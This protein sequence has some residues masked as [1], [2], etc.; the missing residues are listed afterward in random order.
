MPYIDLSP[1]TAR[2]GSNRRPFSAVQRNRAAARSTTTTT[3]SSPMAPSSASRRT[4]R[5]SPPTAQPSCFARQ[6][7]AG[8]PIQLI[9]PCLLAGARLPRDRARP[10]GLYHHADFACLRDRRF[11]LWSDE[12]EH[13]HHADR[14]KSSIPAQPLSLVRQIFQYVSW[15]DGR[16][17]H[18]MDVRSVLERQGRISVLPMASARCRASISLARPLPSVLPSLGQASGATSCAP[19]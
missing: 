9:R 3:T 15:L 4:S 14:G 6:T 2:C 1:W 19:A 8:F 11:G 18:R 16:R 10:V 13:E 7:V 17:W 5:A 12:F